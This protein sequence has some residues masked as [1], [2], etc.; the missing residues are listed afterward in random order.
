MSDLISETAE[1]TPRLFANELAAFRE[2]MRTEKQYSD[3]TVSSYER[4]LHKFIDF[5]EQQSLTSLARLKARDIRQN[6]AHLHRAGLSGKSLH[7]WL[8]ALRS[9]FNFCIRQGW[10]SHNP[11]DDVQAPKANRHLPK[12]LDVDQS[13]QFV[14][15]EGDEFLNCRDHAI[16]EL[17]YSSGLRLAE[18]AATN[19]QDADLQ[20]GMIEVTGKGNKARI[21]P[22]GSKAIEALRTWIAL[23]NTIA[24][25]GEPALFI[26]QKGRRL[27]HRAIQLR[28]QQLSTRQGMD[29]P[30]HPHMLRHSFASHMLESSSDLRLV[31][32]MLGHA[33]ISTTQIYT[34]L[35]F[36]HLA[37]VYDKAHPRAQRRKSAD[38]DT[39]D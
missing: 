13:A 38:D 36:Q 24:P 39:T 34:H 4:D 25:S 12:V 37:S 10:Q 3:K 1:Q 29:T 21:L 5:C 9:F 20:E 26:S 17:F 15:L 7:R 23:R 19:V 18:L 2:F 8:S 14:S 27:G 11:A 28:L 31:Q 6:L 22:I 30:V 35:D 16:L 32:E 33:N